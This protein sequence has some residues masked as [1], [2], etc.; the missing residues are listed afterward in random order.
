[1]TCPKSHSWYTIKRELVVVASTLPGC[2]LQTD[3]EGVEGQ[4]VRKTSRGKT[5]QESQMLG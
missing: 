4:E 1:M 2:H 3:W 5:G